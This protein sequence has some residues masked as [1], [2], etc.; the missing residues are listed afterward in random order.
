MKKIHQLACDWRLKYLG[1]Q[2]IRFRTIALTFK[3]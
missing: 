3:L 2:D 1:E